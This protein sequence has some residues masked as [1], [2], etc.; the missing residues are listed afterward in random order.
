M[1]YHT[2]TVMSESYIKGNFGVGISLPAQWLQHRPRSI[3]GAACSYAFGAGCCWIR[4]VVIKDD[5][6][7]QVRQLS[8]WTAQHGDVADNLQ[9]LILLLLFIYTSTYYDS[10]T[11]AGTFEI[12][13]STK[14]KLSTNPYTNMMSSFIVYKSAVFVGVLAAAVE[15]AR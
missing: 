14:E 9:L 4:P 12:W 1:V 11:C 15:L 8:R 7:H 3:A 13:S 10:Y 2:P 6:G 5:A